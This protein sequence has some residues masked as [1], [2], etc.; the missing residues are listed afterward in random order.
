MSFV[1]IFKKFVRVI[2]APQCTSPCTSVVWNNTLF[3]K[4]YLS[5]THAYRQNL[6][7]F[8][9]KMWYVVTT[10]NKNALT[11]ELWGVYCNGFDKIDRVITTPHCS[12]NILLDKN[13]FLCDITT[14]CATSDN[15]QVSG[16]T[17]Y[18]ITNVSCLLDRVYR[19]LLFDD[20][21]YALLTK[22]FN[23]NLKRQLPSVH[24]CL[25]ELFIFTPLSGILQKTPFPCVCDWYTRAQH[26]NAVWISSTCVR[27]GHCQL[28]GHQMLNG[29]GRVNKS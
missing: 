8:A 20:L 25:P 1:R 26:D 3:G 6:N 7:L 23:Q 5:N 24:G 2:T 21:Q 19:K 11:G 16:S 18:L 27:F 9:N 14:P 10:L 29:I 15:Q 28:T 4:H 17:P 13:T 12:W 22:A